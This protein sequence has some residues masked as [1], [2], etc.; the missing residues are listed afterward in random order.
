MTDSRASYL[1]LVSV[2]GDPEI[3]NIFSERATIAAWLDVET[4]LAAA[5]ASIGIIP[6]EAAVAIASAAHSFVVDVDRLREETRRVGYPILPLLDAL[7]EADDPQVGAY[8]HWGATTQ[9]IMDTGLVLQVERGLRRIE[10]LE[11]LLGDALTHLA[12]THRSAVIAGRTHG[13]QAVPT[14]FGA[15]VA[16]WLDELTRHLER[17]RG[18]RDRVLVVQL[19]GAG[20]TG[21]AM[22]EASPIIRARLAERLGLG[23]TSAPWHTARDTFAE[24]GFDLAAASSTCAKMAREVVDLS[25]SEI[26]E[27]RESGGH[28]RGASS[29]MPQKANPILSEAVVGMGHL[30]IQQVPSLLLAMQAGHERSAGEWQIEWDALPGLFSLAGG[31][32]SGMWSVMSDLQVFPLRMR[33]NL[34]AD[35]GMIMAE[36]VMFAVAPTLGRA[37]AHDLVYGLCAKARAQSRSFEDVICESPLGSGPTA[38]PGLTELLRPERYI[39]EATQTVD[40]AL[41]RW[42]SSRSTMGQRKA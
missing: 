22:G 25:R 34:E 20:G 17:I 11:I 36:A 8:L 38:L 10:Q 2:F 12:L 13:Q 33:A 16:V 24:L 27:V 19:F 41:E 5:Q 40:Y 42:E 30:A 15:K 35:G 26:A 29:T 4:E 39:G 32:L 9:D 31:C 3:A 14:T 18:L 7:A 6:E 37:A 28:H 1:P 21:A 23:T